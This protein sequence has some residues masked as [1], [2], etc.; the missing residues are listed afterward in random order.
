MVKLITRRPSSPVLLDLL[1]CCDLLRRRRGAAGATEP[2]LV[3]VQAA[4]VVRAARA[5]MVSWQDVGAPDVERRVAPVAQHGAAAVHAVDEVAEL[6]PAA[7]VTHPLQIRDGRVE[8]LLRGQLE[9]PHA[10]AVVAHH[11]FRIAGEVRDVR[12]VVSVKV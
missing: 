9:A 12:H 5:A 4:P 7:A 11:I 6:T 10:R 3:D 1:D 2:V 8:A